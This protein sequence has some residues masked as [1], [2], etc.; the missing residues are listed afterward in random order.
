MSLADPME[1]LAELLL[2]NLADWWREIGEKEP[3]QGA[4]TAVFPVVRRSTGSKVESFIGQRAEILD[5]LSVVRSVVQRLPAHLKTVYRLRYVR[6]KSRTDIAFELRIGT[7]TVDRRL[8]VIRGRV[9]G[10]LRRLNPKKL[11]R[12]WQEIGA[13][14]AR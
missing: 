11:A 3:R 10:R 5:V 8:A 6:E 14:L 4:S 1:R 9:A 7:R 12:F 2:V 13:F